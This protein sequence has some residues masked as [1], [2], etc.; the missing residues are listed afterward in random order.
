MQLTK[1][2]FDKHIS[3]LTKKMNSLPTAIKKESA[4]LRSEIEKTNKDI[5]TLAQSVAS[6]FEN[7]D[8][9]FKELKKEMDVRSQMHSMQ[10]RLE[11]LESVS[12]RN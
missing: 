6:G 7:V 5:D 11:R 3:S 10:K 4:R 2:H 9:Q 1:E 12:P 8:S